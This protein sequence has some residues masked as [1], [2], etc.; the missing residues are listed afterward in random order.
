MVALV[1]AYLVIVALRSLAPYVIQHLGA[2]LAGFTRL[3]RL[4]GVLACWGVFMHVAQTRLGAKLARVGPF[5]FFL[6]ATHFPLMAEVK[7]QLWKML[8]E[9]NDFWMVVH[10]L[11][12]V[13]IT[14]LLCLVSAYLLARF[15]PDLFALL[16][17]GRAPTL[18]RP[19]AA[20]APTVFG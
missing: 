10:Y 12:S 9:L 14:I 8:P 11:A 3:M 15:T 6:Y 18:R 7:L 1:V 16:N 4:I 2:L 20:T 13:S 19:A 17:G 5:A